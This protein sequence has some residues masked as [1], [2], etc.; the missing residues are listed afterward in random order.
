MSAHDFE[1]D[2]EDHRL[3]SSFQALLDQS[4]RAEW[5]V[6]LK[7]LRRLCAKGIP[8]HP[9]HLRPLAYS[10]LL[11]TLPPEKPK[12]RST[13]RNQR[14]RYYNLVQTFM[15]ELESQPL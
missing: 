4:T 7:A 14:Q 2:D 15:E 3:L 12:W 9:P 8:N 5:R 6:D 11:E 13:L 10:L 1:E